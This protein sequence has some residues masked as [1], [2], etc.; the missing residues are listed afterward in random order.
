MERV[1]ACTFDCPDTCSLCVE[2][3][4]AG[5]IH[6]RGN[7]DH[8]FTAGFTCAKIRSYVR[9]LSNPQRITRPLLRK[10]A[11]WQ[12]ISWPE[13]LGRCAEAV[14]NC[15][16]EPASILHIQG[17]GAMGVLQLVPKLFFATLGSSTVRGSLCDNAGIEACIAD[18]GSLQSN[19][20]TDL[21]HADRIVNWGKDLS[22]YSVHLAALIKKARKQGTRVLTISPGG[23]GNPPYSDLSI[24]IRPGTDR[25]LAAAV[26]R[27]LLDH[28]R[29]TAS[30]V[31]T[32]G[33]WPAFRELLGAWTVEE[34][35]RRC[36]VSPAD[37]ERLYAFYTEAGTTATLIG[38]GLQRYVCGGENVRFINALALLSG[39]IGRS[40]GGSYFNIGSL[41]NFNRSW[42]TP[43]AAS[44]RRTFLLP[45][46]G[47]ELSQARAPAIRMAWINGS[48]VV[49]QAPGSTSTA[50]ALREIPFKVVVDAFMTDT[51][52]LADLIL[53]CA[54]LFEKEDL[55]GSYLHN[56]VN[57][58][59]AVL[60]PPGE[61]RSDHWI[62][63][64]LGSRLDPPIALP[65]VQACLEAAV[66][67]PYLDTSLE[68]LTAAGFVRAK[69]PSV[70]YTKLRFDHADGRY[71]FPA[72]LHT[73][74]PAPD[75]YPLRL[76]TLIRRKAIH[77]QML[78]EDQQ[79]PPTVWVSPQNPDLPGI[80]DDRKTYLVSPLG[81]LRVKVQTDPRLHPD[82]V[83]Y[84]RGDW[85]QCG[86]GANQLIASRVT[87]LGEGAAFYS[88]YVRLEN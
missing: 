45:N 22:R 43:T 86:G 40:G 47:R 12:P 81:R 3:D 82:V 8:P 7:P 15:R 34:L 56:Y 31:E 32:T 80:R 73:E 4:T 48:N 68:A 39:N 38:W 70:V 30:I 54:L 79:S 2:K 61:A 46:L 24:R 9:R 1:T 41:R 5:R 49:N 88:Q 35:L 76:L 19:D 27:R 67:S 75:G 17:G 29:I 52:R 62:L 85:I 84:R 20:I 42:A 55:V 14:R 66:D 74:P 64:E 37:L 21:L 44:E 11:Q 77:S 59:Q 69:R 63:A 51:A 23:D 72:T 53:P 18:F 10:G 33:N 78:P 71:R 28:D 50:Q 60:E 16:Q 65:T 25:F 87:D 36:D 83:V 6:I 26:M 58:V 57:R 13:A